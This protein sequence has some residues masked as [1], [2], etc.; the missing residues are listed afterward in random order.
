MTKYRICSKGH[1]NEEHQIFCIIPGCA[2]PLSG[3]EPV[4]IMEATEISSPPP[5]AQPE[6]G[7]RVELAR[8]RVLSNRARLECLSQPGFSFPIMPDQIAGRGADVDLTMLAGSDYISGQ[9]AQ[10]M[11]L[12]G[13]WHIKALSRTNGTLVNQML[14]PVDETC[15]VNEGDRITLANSTFIFRIG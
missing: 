10:F 12:D 8:T 6:S 5:A 1:R 3:I 15:P 4:E 14:L 13:Q 2:E 11:L 7:E 9:H